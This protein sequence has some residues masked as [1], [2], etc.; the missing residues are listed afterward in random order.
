VSPKNQRC[1]VVFSRPGLLV[2]ATVGLL[3]GLGPRMYVL[4]GS[5]ELG[6]FPHHPYLF[7]WELVC[8][9]IACAALLFWCQRLDRDR[10]R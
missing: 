3:V 8:Y 10:E 9:A 2:I 6:V 4:L 5:V 7:V 1:R